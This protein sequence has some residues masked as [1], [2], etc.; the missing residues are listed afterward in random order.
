[1]LSS[2]VRCNFGTVLLFLRPTV[3]M[4]FRNF[5]EKLHKHCYTYKRDR[6]SPFLSLFIAFQYASY[7]RPRRRLKH[8]TELVG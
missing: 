1:M 4:E 7:Y 2:T 5:D 8:A 3:P 6:S